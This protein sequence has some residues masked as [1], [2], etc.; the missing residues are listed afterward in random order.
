MRRF[1]VHLVTE[2]EFED[3]RRSIRQ[4]DCGA[5]TEAAFRRCDSERRPSALAPDSQGRPDRSQTCFGRRGRSY[6]C[7]PSAALRGNA[8]A[9]ASYD[10]RLKQ[11]QDAAGEAEKRL[12]ADPGLKVEQEA[13]RASEA[14]LRTAIAAN[15]MAR[16]VSASPMRRSIGSSRSSPSRWV[17]R[18]R[19]PPPSW[20]SSLICSL[21]ARRRASSIA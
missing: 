19:S 5:T 2:V 14:R 16:L 3:G 8:S 4:G 6:D 12:Q 1:M 13:V 7:T 20:P 11:A 21:A 9:Q 10:S 17:S 15:P 18:S